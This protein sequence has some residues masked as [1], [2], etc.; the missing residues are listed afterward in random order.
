[1][2]ESS[3]VERYRERPARLEAPEV[4]TVAIA[5]QAGGLVPG[6]THAD[7]AY[8]RGRFLASLAAEGRPRRMQWWTPAGLASH[9]RLRST[10]MTEAIAEAGWSLLGSGRSVLT[11]LAV[12]IG[13]LCAALGG[14]VMRAPSDSH[15]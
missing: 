1:M 15:A 8:A 10:A 11:P 14:A 4:A 2:S 12:V 9:V 7:L 6:P 13:I 5:L 3:W